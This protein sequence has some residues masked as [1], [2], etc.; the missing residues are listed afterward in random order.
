MI[1]V[2]KPFSRVIFSFFSFAVMYL[3]ITVIGIIS[4]FLA[5]NHPKHHYG[6]LIGGAIAPVFVFFYSL[7]TCLTLSFK[8]QVQEHE[9]EKLISKYLCTNSRVYR[10]GCDI[11]RDGN[12]T[13]FFP[14][15]SPAALFKFPVKG[16]LFKYYFDPMFYY[17]YLKKNNGTYC[18]IGSYNIMRNIKNIT[19]NLT[20]L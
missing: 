2:A 1:V 9:L 6:A 14:R 16:F 11:Y 17:V 19:A 3:M 18:L 20:H 15:N 13:R 4:N 10:F 12:I 8:E 7:P 5:D